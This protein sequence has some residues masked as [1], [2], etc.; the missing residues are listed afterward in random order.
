MNAASEASNVLSVFM[1][2]HHVGSLYNETPLGFTYNSTWLSNPAANSLNPT[3]P[4]QAEKITS[5]EV[6]AFFENLLPEGEQRKIIS[7]RHHVSTIFGLLSVVGGDTAGSIVF[8]PL[9]HVPQAPHYQSL[10][11]SQ[12]D[13]LI[14]G[15][16]LE[17]KR[18]EKLI[19]DQEEAAN[20][21]PTLSGAQYKLLIS[22]DEN[23]SPLLPL[24]SSPT[25]H[26]LKPDI[27]RH[28]VNIFSSAINETIVMRTA[29]LCG[30]PTA[31][32]SYQSEVK[33]CLVKRYDRIQQ[34]DGTLRRLWQADFCQLLGKPSEV[35]YEIDG[36]PTFKECFNLLRI[37]SAQPAIDQRNLLRW[38]FFNLYVGNN[39]SHAKNLSI[40]SAAES[41]QDLQLAP[42]YD[43]MSTRVYAGF[44]RQFTF[45]INGEYVPGKITKTHI[46]AFARLLGIKTNYVMKIA[47]DMAEQVENSI[48]IAAQEI[49]L[50]LS[51]P[52]K[53]MAE[54]IQQE[55]ASIVNKM[56]NRLL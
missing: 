50:P 13:Q 8:L 11:W 29:K 35:K 20:S 30:L 34:A 22:L 56:C 43:L 24:G 21:R 17:G 4:L 45:Q 7:M 54:R 6:H 37:Y 53:V 1:D 36:G 23:G 52:E 32:V 40:L 51:S 19:K 41:R 46:E 38:L 5:P 44:A 33:A 28:D 26:I 48:R 12:V 49:A 31:D 42:F 16:A 9:G 2:E 55:I 27:I 18:L 10:N 14:H 39:D 47:S 3:L 15:G 25:T